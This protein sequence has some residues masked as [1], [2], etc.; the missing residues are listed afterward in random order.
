MTLICIKWTEP[1][2]KVNQQL[3]FTRILLITHFTTGYKLKMTSLVS[4]LARVISALVQWLYGSH[5]SLSIKIIYDQA[6][7]SLCR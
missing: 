5:M 4:V 6:K 1:S 3:L 2:L 7:V